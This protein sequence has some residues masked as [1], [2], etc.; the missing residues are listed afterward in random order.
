MKI[1][2]NIVNR[3]DRKRLKFNCKLYFDESDIKN[4]YLCIPIN[5]KNLH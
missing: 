3:A 4:A 2:N 5:N 1:S